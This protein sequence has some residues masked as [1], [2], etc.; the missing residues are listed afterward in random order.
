MDLFLSPSYDG[1]RRALALNGTQ[2][3]RT[4][5]RGFYQICFK[6]VNDIEYYL[7]MRCTARSID[8][9]NVEKRDYGAEGRGA[10][11]VRK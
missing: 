3:C 2:E 10:S 8:E 11:R 6:K 9:G 5:F 1:R 4:D 7:F